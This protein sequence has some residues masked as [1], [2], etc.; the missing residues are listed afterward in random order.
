[1]GMGDSI[2]KATE[3]AM[4]DLA[5]T[6]PPADDAH[7]PE[8]GAADE[9]IQVHSSISEGANAAE[10]ERGS[11][12]SAQN[13]AR[14]AVQPQAPRARPGTRTVQ[15]VDPGR[16]PGQRSPPDPRRTKRGRRLRMYR[17]MCQDRP[18]C[19]TRTPTS[20]G[21]TCPKATRT[22]RQ[23]SGAAKPRPC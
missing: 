1:M 11:E 21:L 3:N 5:G 9:D 4:K 13:S 10:G 19:P 17:A 2:R 8:P 7:A 6:A 12:A 23:A 16:M 18:G 20:C 15:G 14:D 22:R